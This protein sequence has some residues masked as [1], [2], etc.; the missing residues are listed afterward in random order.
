MFDYIIFIAHFFIVSAD[1]CIL[2]SYYI[3]KLEKMLYVLKNFY[4]FII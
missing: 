4:N 1:F 2:I 3:T